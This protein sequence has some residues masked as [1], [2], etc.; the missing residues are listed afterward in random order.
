M[1]KIKVL[2]LCAI[3][4]GF[5][6]SCEKSDV[7]SEA[8][9]EAVTESI[10]KEHREA[11]LKTGVSDFGAEYITVQHP[12]Q[13]PFDAI[14]A[15]GDI[16]FALDQLAQNIHALEQGENNA[17][18]YRTRNLVSQGRTIRVTGWTGSGNALTSKMRTGL[19]WAVNNY[20][21]INISLNFVLTFGTDQGSNVDMVVYNNNRSGGGGSAGFPSGGR[22]NKYIQINAGTDSF[23]TNVNEH[24]IG[25]EMG[26]SVGL[27]HTNYA[28]RNCPDGSNEGDGGVGAIHIP[29]TPTANQTGQAG[30]DTDSF[31]IACF[32][33]NEDGE[34][35][36]FDRIALE[37]LY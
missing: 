24:V 2:A 8:Q 7:A 21:R 22:P 12:G 16:I 37:A 33:G 25:H 6:T 35:S 10:S 13:Q 28:R 29:G 23:S 9:P 14:L 20:N 5:S 31:M 34:F 32:S 15:D 1:K 27:R 4:A 36:N 30:L 11:L 17:K 18:Q 26:H 19:Q 3:V